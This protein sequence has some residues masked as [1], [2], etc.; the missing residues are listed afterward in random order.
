MTMYQV[1]DLA[2]SARREFLDQA[3]MGS[4]ALRDTDGVVLVMSSQAQWDSLR[5]IRNIVEQFVT[6]ERVLQKVQRPAPADLGGFAWLAEFD[7]DDRAVA[8]EEIRDAIVLALSEDDLSVFR[9]VVSAWATTAVVMRDPVRGRVLR[10]VPR[11]EDFVEVHA[12]T[13]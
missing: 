5:E 2:G 3:K 10:S 7:E 4:A 8:V 9:T 11:D 6:L 12:P 13:E 1:S